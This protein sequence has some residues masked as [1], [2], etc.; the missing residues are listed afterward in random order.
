MVSNA[1]DV[2]AKKIFFALNLSEQRL[3][4]I[5]SIKCSKWATFRISSRDVQ[6]AFFLHQVPNLL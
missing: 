5:T 2:V 1:H 4:G 6:E 3:K